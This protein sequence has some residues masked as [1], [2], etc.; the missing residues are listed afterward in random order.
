LNI[1]DEAVSG[2]DLE[3]LEIDSETNSRHKLILNPFLKKSFVFSHLNISYNPSLFISIFLLDGGAEKERISQRLPSKYFYYLSGKFFKDSRHVYS[4]FKKLRFLKYRISRKVRAKRLR[5]YRKL[6]K[7]IFL[8]GRKRRRR[9]RYKLKRKNVRL[10]YTYKIIRLPSGQRLH[11]HKVAPK[12]V[13]SGHKAQFLKQRRLKRNRKLRATKLRGNRVTFT[14]KK[15]R[16]YRFSRAALNRSRLRT[17]R[18]SFWF[19]NTSTIGLY[20]NISYTI[21]RNLRILRF[22]LRYLKF[23]NKNFSKKRLF[24]FNLV[25]ISLSSL[26]TLL[27]KTKSANRLFLFLNVCYIYLFS[28]RY[29]YLQYNKKIYQSRFL[30]FNFLSKFALFSLNKVA[31]ITTENK[32]ILRYYG[33]HNR[34]YNAQFFLHYILTKLSQY[35]LLNDIINP[36]L[37]RLKRLPSVKGY[38]FIISGRLTR[39]E[40]ASFILKS[41]GTMPYSRQDVRIDVASGFKI[42]KFGVVGIKIHLLYTNTPPYYYYF[43]FRNKI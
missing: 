35:F 30:L 19:I 36:I 43:E 25:I 5:Y 17:K 3:K 34:N 32:V 18:F 1:Q 15:R 4:Y 20:G 37:Y 41:H 39:A 16:K 40:R 24:L 29:K 38:R 9:Y 26:L 12:S 11:L 8:R 27:G 10:R 6:R 13:I 21:L 2:D 28:F 33:L 22:L 31:F 7:F 42:M 23:F 14:K